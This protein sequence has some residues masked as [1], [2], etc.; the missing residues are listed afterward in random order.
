VYL[1]GDQ[2][3]ISMI[4]VLPEKEI[5]SW[6]VDLSSDDRN[7]VIHF[8]RPDVS[9]YVLPAGSVVPFPENY[10]YSQRQA[11]RG[12][13]LCENPPIKGRIESGAVFTISLD[14]ID[15]GDDILYASD[16]FR[17]TVSVLPP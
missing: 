13:I 9:Q 10:K 14:G 15:F 12:V 1:V 5:R 16:T 7:S 8:S 6:R 2:D 11:V 17:L 3:V 4:M